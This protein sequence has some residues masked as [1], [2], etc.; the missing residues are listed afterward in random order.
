[1]KAYQLGSDFNFM[2]KDSS[3]T[4]RPVAFEGRQCRRN[5]VRLHSHLGKCFAGNWAINKNRHMLFGQQF[6]WVTDCYAARFILSY[7]GNN[8]AVLRLQMCL[9][10]RDI[11][12]VHRNNIHLT[13]AD[14][15]SRLGADICFDPLFKSYLDFD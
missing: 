15:W 6:V 5:Q 1:M 8:P 2:T 3:A 12:I 9:M 11:D 10:C 4:I 13:D 7:D 14:Y